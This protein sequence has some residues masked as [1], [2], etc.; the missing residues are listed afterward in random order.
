MALRDILTIRK[1]RFLAIDDVATMELLGSLLATGYYV[2]T[3]V[4]V[5]I[6]MISE[7]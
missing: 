7:I 4:M 5:F 6:V 3:L 1:V 2:G